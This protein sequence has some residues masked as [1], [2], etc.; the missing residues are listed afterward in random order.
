[1]RPTLR[2]AEVAEIPEILGPSGTGVLGTGEVPNA[3]PHSQY[4]SDP[5]LREERYLKRL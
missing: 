4:V 5:T 2:D 3:S 1:M